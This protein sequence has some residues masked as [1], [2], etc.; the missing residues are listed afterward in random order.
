MKKYLK[1]NLFC[2]L[3]LTM[4]SL[5]GCSKNKENTAKAIYLVPKDG[6]QLTKEDL[7]KY[8][9]VTCVSDL[10]EMKKLVSKNTAIWV[11]KDTIDLLDLDWIQKEAES[12]M[13]IVLIGYNDA[14]YSF[15]EILSCYDIEGPYID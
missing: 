14:L 11:D 2:I 5:I 10:K 3:I 7:S 13:P 4:V 9:E 8:P 1:F 15:R 12:E 6:G